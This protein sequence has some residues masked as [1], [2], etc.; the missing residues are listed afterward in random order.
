[1]LGNL[2]IEGISA[3]KAYHNFKGY[4]LIAVN[5]EKNSSARLQVKSRFQ[6]GWNGFIINNF[7]CDFVIL[8]SLNRGY[9]KPKKN[10]ESGIMTPDFYVFPVA[11]VIEAGKDKASWGKIS[12][13]KLKNYQEYKNKW[14][15]ISDFLN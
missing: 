2:L 8:V 4:D 7:D 6:T 9:T 3:F 13:S 5:A 10:G 12:K 14:D 1:M 15:L 11:Y